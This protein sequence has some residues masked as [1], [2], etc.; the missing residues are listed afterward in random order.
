[1]LQCWSTDKVVW[2]DNYCYIHPQGDTVPYYVV[3]ISILPFVPNASLSP[4]VL[5]LHPI[6]QSE[7]GRCYFRGSTSLLEYSYQQFAEVTISE[8]EKHFDKIEKE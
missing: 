7:R 1:M 4:M 2:L 3:E 8:A 5:Q 6:Y